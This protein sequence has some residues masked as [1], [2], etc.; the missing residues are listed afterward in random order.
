MKHIR[1]ASDLHIESWRQAK[2]EKV[3]EHFLPHD[4][5]DKDSILVLAGD[6]SSSVNQLVDFIAAVAPRFGHVIA[7]PGNHEFYGYVLADYED[8]WKAVSAERLKDIT[9]VSYCANQEQATVVVLGNVRFVCST[10]WADGGL[11]KA[12]RER[13]ESSLFDFFH[14]KRVDCSPFT[15]HD[16]IGIHAKQRYSIEGILATPFDGKTVVVTHHLP[17][18]KLVSSRFNDPVNGINGGFASSLDDVLEGENAPW[19][20]IF[21]HTHDTIH[22]NIGKTQLVCNPCGYQRETNMS[23]HN[24]YQPRFISLE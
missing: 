18:L 12:E 2:I 22:R 10:L 17:S 21:G 15:V 11:S 7:I 3:V 5:D 16:M 19:L 9:N 8:Y 1:Y 24:T 4:D 23:Q 6:I 14:I 13:V 20:W